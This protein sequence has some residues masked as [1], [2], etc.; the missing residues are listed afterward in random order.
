MGSKKDCSQNQAW[1]KACTHLN[2]PAVA[3]DWH[4]A[5]AAAPSSSTGRSELLPICVDQL[6]LLV[7][8]TA[9]SPTRALYTRRHAMK[10]TKI[11]LQLLSYTTYTASATG[12][13]V[14]NQL[15][16]AQLGTHIALPETNGMKNANMR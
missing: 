6:L 7:L 3:I 11:K 1:T 2:R 12:K 16:L 13:D 14:L 4:A 9:V 10:N 8:V 5:V 15:V